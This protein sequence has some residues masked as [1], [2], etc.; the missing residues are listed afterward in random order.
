M[1]LASLGLLDALEVIREGRF[2][3]ED[4]TRACLARMEEVEPQVKAWEWIEPD[5]ALS[6]AREA[7]RQLKMGTPPAPLQ[8]IPVGIKDIML[9][10]GVPT[11]MGSPIYAGQVPAASASVIDRIQG[12]GGFVMGKTVTTEFAWRHP[13]KTHNPWNF[14]HT[15]GGSSSG[16]AAAVAAGMVPAALGTQTVG[17]VIRP[18]AYCGVVGYKPSFGLISRTGV[19]PLS[20][21]LDHV[22]V[23]AR[24]VE[25]AAYLA[26]CL[27]GYDSTDPGSLA[28]GALYPGDAFGEAPAFKPRLAAVRTPVWHLADGIQQSMWERN[29]EA[30]AAAGAEVEYVD[31]PPSF[32]RALEV[33]R[34]I[35]MA[36]GAQIY[37]PLQAANPDKTSP[38][39]DGLIEMGR[40]VAAVD[41]I[42]ALAA[43]KAM[44]AELEA[45]LVRFD[46]II[47][48]PATGEAPKTLA[49]TGDASFC[50]IWTL[51]GV[52]AV[53]FPVGYGPAGL[54]L[55]LQ[56]VGGYLA[57]RKTLDVARWCS[58]QVGIRPGLTSISA[59][60]A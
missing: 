21:S 32:Q 50:G 30:L 55:G 18:A 24:S 6:A 15:P 19:H 46:A 44:R 57:D 26:A 5:Y 3:A 40:K 1:E 52:P 27:A 45:F 48:P 9:T 39:L 31:L 37:G 23:F 34:T 38:P 33:Q 36:E 58:R 16:S 29:V 49:D 11:G 51:M 8:G 2:S 13:G 4:L 22:G 20:H 14:G 43:A 59:S 35:L 28:A 10:K 17:S 41:Y 42:N 7:D 56:V 60:A 53:T 12:M 54:P 25:D 47:T